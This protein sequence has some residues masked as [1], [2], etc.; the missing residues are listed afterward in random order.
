M[1]RMDKH[2]PYEIVDVAVV[3]GYGTQVVIRTRTRYAL[4]KV[5]PGESDWNRWLGASR[6]IAME[7]GIKGELVSVDLQGYEA[8][9]SWRENG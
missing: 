4:G 7:K 8:Q 2:A 9:L 1:K 5:L 6:A 3:P